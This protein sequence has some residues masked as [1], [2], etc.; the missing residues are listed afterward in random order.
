MG[1]AIAEHL[2]DAGYVVA[3]YDVDEDRLIDLARLGGTPTASV[4]D[5]VARSDLV[6]TSLPSE[7][8]FRN[9]IAE[10][11]STAVAGLVVADTST[12]A[13]NVKRDA[14]HLLADRSVELLDCPLSGTGA[15]ARARDLVA[16]M[17]GVREEVEA[18]EPAFRAFCRDCRFVGDFGR[19]TDLKLVANLLVAVHT[20]AAAE[21]LVLAERLGLDLEVVIAALTDSAAG[22]KMFE[23]RGPA[24][25]TDGWRVPNMRLDMF[26]KDLNLIGDLAAR[27]H[28][29]T[30]LFSTAVEYYQSANEL[31]LG[32]CDSASVVEALRLTGRETK[33][34][35]S[36][37]VDDS[38]TQPSRIE[39]L[40]RHLARR[41]RL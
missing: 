28:S 13:S 9:V 2:T 23:V 21:A 35:E 1:S 27:V 7:A 17:S 19:G 14:H 36:L 12:L 41:F 16:F 6:I 11:C 22:S 3:G 20:F 25:T 34:G 5:L 37:S 40:G 18:V 39:L 31:G 4:G 38:R 26:M 10:M 30:P 32:D 29:P 8:A 15:Q 24:M 33:S